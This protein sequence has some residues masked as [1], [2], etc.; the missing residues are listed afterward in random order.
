MGLL[1]ADAERTMRNMG[2]FTNR[3]KIEQAIITQ[4]E[5][6]DD[7]AESPTLDD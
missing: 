6:N 3:L 4:E 2:V 5:T 1:I 7:H